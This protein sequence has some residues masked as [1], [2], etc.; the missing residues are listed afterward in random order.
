MSHLRFLRLVGGCFATS[1]A[2][3]VGAAPAP[4][5]PPPASS[6]RSNLL[7]KNP[8]QYALDVMQNECRDWDAAGMERT[9]SCAK[10]RERLL[11]AVILSGTSNPALAEE[12]AWETGKVLAASSVS[13]FPDGEC[14][15]K[16]GQS[17]R[18]K[19]VYI[20]QSSTAPINDSFVESLLLCSAAR[21]A[22]A[23]TITLLA[24]SMPYSRS[25]G[26]KTGGS[27]SEEGLGVLQDARGAAED[28]GSSSVSSAAAA[29]PRALKALLASHAWEADSEGSAVSARL[30]AEGLAASAAAA[31]S[32][33]LS[34][35]SR[36][37]AA[38][39][40]SAAA[41]A[42]PAEANS[43]SA[44]DCAI[45]LVASG[46]DRIISVELS[47]PG[48][49]QSEG[50]FPPQVPVES[51]R[52]SAIMVD[53]VSRFKLARPVVVSPNEDCIQLALD[54]RAGM[55]KE[56]PGMDVG[57]ACIVGECAPFSLQPPPLGR[58]CPPPLHPPPSHSCPPPPSA[59]LTNPP[60]LF[61]KW[62]ARARA[63]GS[64]S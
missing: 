51:L 36:S 56:R 49:G 24:P 4:A 6:R 13:R 42:T 8:R 15:I 40:P 50:F 58:T 63:R 14:D 57:L 30:R 25:T 17:L 47:P 35:A 37:G 54:I 7:D 20:V 62:L 21:R 9:L 60:P 43:I 52:A 38:A 46:V 27:H 16:I 45:M 31:A 1:A 55:Q 32:V 26:S 33:L 61:Q 48:V 64:C 22:S 28:E 11:N 5:P 41:A 44:A 29:L 23:Q 19:D 3:L 59:L 53:F 12:V 39:A 34:A 2:A 10:M 18:G